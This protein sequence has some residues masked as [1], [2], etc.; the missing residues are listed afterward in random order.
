MENNTTSTEAMPLEEAVPSKRGR[1]PPIVL[2]SATNLIQWRIQ[3]NGVVKEQFE[4]RSTRNRTR[5][6]T[7]DILPVI[8]LID[9]LSLLVP[10]LLQWS[11]CSYT[12]WHSEGPGS[13]TTTNKYCTDLP[14]LKTNLKK[15]KMHEINAPVQS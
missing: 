15:R 8:M 6:I 7:K 3:L 14:I 11:G 13:T 4:F 1:L 9:S 10:G 5:I 2:T 12:I